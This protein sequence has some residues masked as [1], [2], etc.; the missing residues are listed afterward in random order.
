MSPDC[1]SNLLWIGILE[2]VVALSKERDPEWP[3]DDHSLELSELL[4]DHCGADHLVETWARR[5]G[6]STVSGGKLYIKHH[7]NCHNQ[8]NFFGEILL[9]WNVHFEWR[10]F[11]CIQVWRHFP[12]W[13]TDQCYTETFSC[14]DFSS[15]QKHLGLSRF[16]EF[17]QAYIWSSSSFS[18][19]IILSKWRTVVLIEIMETV[20]AF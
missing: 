16:A 14:P 17:C 8:S 3:S 11:Y 5:Q 7:H 2:L 13:K 6:S 10:E 20:L 15:L 19:A 9:V 12:N 1:C 18:F 4:G